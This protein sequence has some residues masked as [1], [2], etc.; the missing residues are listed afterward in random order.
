MCYTEEKVYRLKCNTWN[1]PNKYVAHDIKRRWNS[2][3]V[4]E[5][6]WYERGEMKESPMYFNYYTIIMYL[7]WL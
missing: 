3:L 1:K 4:K 2:N 6:A 7:F 5:M